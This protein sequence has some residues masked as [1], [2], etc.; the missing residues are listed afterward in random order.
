MPHPGRVTQ[1]IDERDAAAFRDLG[2]LIVEGL[3]S[4]QEVAALQSTVESFK[5]QNLLCVGPPPTSARVGRAVGEHVCV[6]GL[7]PVFSLC[8]SLDAVA[9]VRFVVK[10]MAGVEARNWP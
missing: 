9:C 6:C 2:Y 3:F 8:A 10:K 5:Q 7:P 1:P 4:R